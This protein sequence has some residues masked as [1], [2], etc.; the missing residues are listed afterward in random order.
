MTEFRKLSEQYS[1]LFWNLIV[2]NFLYL[3]SYKTFNIFT[4]KLHIISY[5]QTSEISKSYKASQQML[6]LYFAHFLFIFSALITC[7][8]EEY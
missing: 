6:V 4:K 3:N 5:E 8:P 2:N 1:K 7:F